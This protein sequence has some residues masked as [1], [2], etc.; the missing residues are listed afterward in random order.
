MQP[1]NW[2]RFCHLPGDPTTNWERLCTHALRRNYT[3]IGRFEIYAQQPGI[4]LLLRLEQIS[5]RL[6]E[7]PRCWGCQCRWYDLPSGRAI[8]TRRRKSIEA[9]IRKTEKY[10]PDVT[11]WVLWTR[12]PLTPNDQGWFRAICTLMKLHL[13]TADLVDHLVGEAAVLRD[14]YFGE[15]VLTPDT[16]RDLRER[17]IA[18][19][20]RRWVPHLHVMMDAE[21]TIRQALGDPWYAPRIAE[22]LSAISATTAE[23]DALTVSMDDSAEPSFVNLVGDL[24]YL[25]A[26]FELIA[27]ALNNGEMQL[28]MHLILDDWEPSPDEKSS[29]YAYSVRTR[30]APRG[31]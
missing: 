3:S 11:D 13:W 17:S 10:F 25:S 28:V 16:L 27:Q 1:L 20:R 8:G 15:L 31:N 30:H 2:E 29:C 22:C 21:Q 23:L 14:A 7:P 19:V 18:P 9:A 26:K 5:Q 12:H 4:E 24:R 6:G